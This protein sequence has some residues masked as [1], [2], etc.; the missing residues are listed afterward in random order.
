MKIIVD[1]AGE[2]GTH[3]A[4]MLSR[5]NHQIIVLD[6][7]EA[8]L[9]NLDANY[10]LQTLVGSPT[11][12]EKMKE[13][14]ASSCD[15]FIAVTPDESRNLTACILAA[16]LGAKKTVARIDN[17]E[18]MHEE[19]KAFFEQLGIHSLIYPELLAA[20]E[21]VNSLKRP[22][23]RQWHEFCQGKLVLIG[24][25]VR[26][27][28]PILGKTLADVF[29]EE[30]D[31]RVAA[32]KR[33]N[34]TLIPA[35]KDMI[36]HGDL[37]Y[38]IAKPS[39]VETVRRLSG[40]ASDDIKNVM[41]MGGS[42]IAVKTTQLLGN[43]FSLKMIEQNRTRIDWLTSCVNPE[44]MIIHGDGR[45]VEL[46]ESEGI[47]EMDAFIALTGSAETNILS[48]LEAKRFNTR[49]TIAEVENIDYIP[50]AD[51]LDIGMIINKKVLA[52]SHIYQMMLAADVSNVKSLTFADAEVAEFVVSKK[53][54]I[55]K[56]PVKDLKLPEDISLGGLVRNGK[57]SL[58]YGDT[59]LEEGDHVVVFCPNSTI[60]R[61]EKYFK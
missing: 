51:G 36:Q 14:G 19:H 56:A 44:T 12:I 58:I 37:V 57:A 35:G 5:E 9:S 15:L 61:I 32:I 60:N 23:A 34:T 48:C 45:D 43:D 22:W 21:I 31:L 2:V 55:T 24:V 16:K 20:K 4:K 52:A 25:K 38:Y 29:R 50:L 59:L 8:H 54:R 6:N 10:D 46:L 40:K 3:L 47:K 18:Y 26:E 28:A 11:S 13:A 27:G 53:A 7:N 33:H 49:R 39:A 17:A 42:R 41:F 1:G 30:N